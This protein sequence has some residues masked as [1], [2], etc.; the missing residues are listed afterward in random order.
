MASELGFSLP[1]L[2]SPNSSADPLIR[3]ALSEIKTS[4]NEF[5]GQRPGK[6]YT[7]TAIAAEQSTPSATFTTLST[8]DEITGVVMPANGIMMIG[9][10]ALAKQTVST[11]ARA[12]I[13]LGA[14]QLKE[15]GVNVQETSPVSGT[16][17]YVVGSYSSGLQAVSTGGV[18]PATTGQVLGVAPA[19]GFSGLVAVFAA[20]GTYNVSVKWK[21][22]SGSVSAKER[23]LW[24]Y[25]LGV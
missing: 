18:T 25:V 11:A 19:S 16:S 4:H 10:W 7:P 23:K 21:V 14:N 12:A 13:F 6:W 5:V 22:S 8:P 17:E 15:S 9:Y 20:A 3:T 2:G 24:V 1:E